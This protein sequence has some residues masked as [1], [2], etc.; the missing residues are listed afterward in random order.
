MVKPRIYESNPIRPTPQIE[1][2][3]QK[4]HIKLDAPAAMA[5]TGFL[6]NLAIPEVRFASGAVIRKVEVK[7]PAGMPYPVTKDELYVAITLASCDGQPLGVTKKAVIS[8]VSTSFNTGFELDTA[9]RP[10]PEFKGA[11]VKNRGNE[12][13]LVARG[14]CIVECQALAG[15]SYILRDYHMQELGK[16]TIG[17]DGALTIS[18]DMAVFVVELSR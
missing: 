2:D 6:G 14:G 3:W 9:K 13:V 17:K 16:G 7:N 4:G 10:L 8:A 15:M 18:S 5:Y 12:P 11:E 1:Y